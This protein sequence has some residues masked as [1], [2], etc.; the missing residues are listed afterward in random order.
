VRNATDARPAR[1]SLAP[2]SQ[3]KEPSDE[4]AYRIGRSSSPHPLDWRLS[5]GRTSLA[6]DKPI[7]SSRQ[8]RAALTQRLA[9][10][11]NL[12][13]IGRQQFARQLTIVTEIERSQG[14]STAARETLHL[15]AQA[16]A[17]RLDDRDRLARLLEQA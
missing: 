5:L 14:D 16:H 1:I 12:I 11:E 10:V 8:S 17:I 2:L 6:T 15:F 9:Q 7:R 3:A 13:T 4:C